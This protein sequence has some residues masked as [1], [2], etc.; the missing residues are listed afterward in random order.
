MPVTKRKLNKKSA[1]LAKPKK[2]LKSPFRYAGGKLY[3]SGF[4][5]T[6]TNDPFNSKAAG[7]PDARPGA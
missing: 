7:T 3:L 1:K 4:K 2:G 6:L 5:E